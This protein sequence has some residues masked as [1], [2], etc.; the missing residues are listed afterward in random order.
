MTV[1]GA[2]E[3]GELSVSDRLKDNY[4]HYYEEGESEWRWLSSVAKVK[5]ILALCDRYPHKSILEVGSGDGS[6]LQRMSDLGFGERLDSLEISRSAVETIL[7]KNIGSLV[8]CRLFNGYD[9]PYEDNQFDLVILSHV[10][11]HLEFPRKML[12]EAG[13]VAKRV[14]VEVPLEDNWRLSRDFVF[15]RVGHINFYSLKTIRRL[16]Q[17]C[18]LEISSQIVTNSSYQVYKYHSAKSGPPKFLIKELLLR[19]SP[20]LAT[21][22]WTYHS[23][24]ICTKK[25]V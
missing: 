4:E 20:N 6:I 9:I 17:T 8:D 19:L 3:I 21:H 12:Y 22:L 14:F 16:I 5:N 10:V 18:D 13:R 15:D 25:Q 7:H 24:M 11:E 1:S 2:N 23:A